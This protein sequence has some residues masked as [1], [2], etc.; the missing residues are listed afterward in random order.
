MKQP[1]SIEQRGELLPKESVCQRRAAKAVCQ[2]A[3]ADCLQAR[4]LRL[5]RVHQPLSVASRPFSAIR[6]DARNGRRRN[7]ERLDQARWLV[8]FAPVTFWLG[9]RSDASLGTV[10]D[11][12]RSRLLFARNIATRS[13]RSEV[14]CQRSKIRRP[15]SVI[16]CLTFVSYPLNIDGSVLRSKVACGL[17]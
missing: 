14:R 5:R 1:S 13:Q 4:T 17:F 12:S 2:S 8:P 6:P 11:V 7:L 9:Q 16:G 3:P 10:A 15:F